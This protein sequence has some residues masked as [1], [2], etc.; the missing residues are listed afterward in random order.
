MLK[1]PPIVQPKVGRYIAFE[2]MKR[3]GMKRF[4]VFDRTKQDIVGQMYC[5]APN[6]LDSNGNSIYR[7]NYLFSYIQNKG[8]GKI[9]TN[10]AKNDSKRG[11]TNG[12]VCLIATDEYDKQNP[13]YLFYKKMGFNAVDKNKD[14]YLNQCLKKGVDVSSDCI[15]DC[16]EMEYLPTK[17]ELNAIKFIK[18]N[19]PYLFN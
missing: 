14:N 6:K 10:I 13:P 17:K 8:I 12:K 9:L 3:N 18:Q 7:I 4:V 16:V 11:I 15:S 1:F 5:F 19:F 2:Q